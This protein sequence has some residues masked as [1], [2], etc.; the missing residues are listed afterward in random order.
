MRIK[1]SVKNRLGQSLMVAGLCS[2]LSGMALADMALT[3]PEM[4]PV[5]QVAAS[6][7]DTSI[8]TRVMVS[9][10]NQASLDQSD[11]H[12]MTRHRVVTLTGSADSD[13]ARQVAENSARSIKGVR[14]VQNDLV[15]MA[16]NPPQQLD[17][18]AYTTDEDVS[19]SGIIARVKA[20]MLADRST[21]SYGVRVSSQQGAVVLQGTVE[22]Q[23]QIQHV[24][25]LVLRVQ[26]VKSVDS[27]ALRVS[28][29]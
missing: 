18:P 10:K 25:D 12:V 1:T 6:N 24:N 15:V 9:L 5:S 13:H 23:E 27:S 19:D 7:R 26:G 11:I 29:Q 17:K 4:L 14:R 16:G 28:G 21:R 20:E 8:N 22:S 2:G 3:P